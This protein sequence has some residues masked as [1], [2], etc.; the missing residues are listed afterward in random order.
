V[1]ITLGGLATGLAVAWTVRQ[2][3]RLEAAPPAEP[4]EPVPEVDTE[5]AAAA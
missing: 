3:R 4:V 2:M 5:A 1:A